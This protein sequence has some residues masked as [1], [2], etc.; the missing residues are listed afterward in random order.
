MD[1]FLWGVVK[2]NVYL[3]PLPTTLHELKTQ[4]REACENTDQEI[5]H[6]VWQVV[7]YRF[8]VARASRGDHTEL[9]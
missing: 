2:D 8:D 4:I 6:K 9:Q 7:E 3:P 1:F 5:L